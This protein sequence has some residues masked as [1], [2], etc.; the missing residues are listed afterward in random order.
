MT[1]WAAKGILLTVF[2]MMA[3]A[4]DMKNREIP[5]FIPISIIAVGLIGITLS[6]LPAAICGLIITALPYFVAAV[7]VRRGSFAIGGGDI[8]LMAA[9]GFVLG[10]WGGVLQSMVSLT[11]VVIAGAVVAAVR[12]KKFSEVQIPLAPCFCAGGILSFMAVFAAAI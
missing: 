9:C 10:I 2:L 4:W 8:K 6:A 3:A 1:V 7:A 5:D 12:K 11:L